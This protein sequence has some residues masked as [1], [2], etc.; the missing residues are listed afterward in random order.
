MHVR[1]TRRRSRRAAC[2]ACWAAYLAAARAARAQSGRLR[3]RRTTRRAERARSSSSRCADC[4][5]VACT[6]AAALQYA[7]ACR[8]SLAQQAM[9]SCSPSLAR[10]VSFVSA[11][12]LLFSL[13]FLT[14]TLT[15]GIRVA[16]PYLTVKQCPH[17]A[18]TVNTVRLSSPSNP[19]A[20]SLFHSCFVH[21]SC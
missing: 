9:C 18:H 7:T 6:G 16:L 1:R 14:P 10:A 2:W 3:P 21:V 8:L 11:G 5:A 13:T 4:C 12:V 19:K 20:V 17:I 15:V